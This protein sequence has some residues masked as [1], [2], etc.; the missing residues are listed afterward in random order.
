MDYEEE[1]MARSGCNDEDVQAAEVALCPHC[2]PQEAYRH[3]V[4]GVE[5][6]TCCRCYHEGCEGM[7]I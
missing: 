3:I 7:V 6:L 4:N 2:G 1:L 5:V